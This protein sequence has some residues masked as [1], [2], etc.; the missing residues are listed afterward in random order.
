MR[1]SGTALSWALGPAITES[2]FFETSYQRRSLSLPS[3]ERDRFATL[4]DREAL[5]RAE[6]VIAADAAT[7]DARGHQVQRE[8]EPRELAAWLA[9]GWTVCADVSSHP[10]VQAFLDGFTTSF[11]VAGARPFAKAYA[12]PRGKGFALHADAHEV[13][14]LQLAGE[15]RW[16][17][18]RVP[19]LASPW[20]ALE[21]S[22]GE[23][24]YVEPRAGER[25]RD[26]NGEPLEPPSAGS[27]EEVILRS[28]DVLYLPAGA[29]HETEAVSESLA[30]SVSPPL[31]RGRDVAL[32]LIAELLEGERWRRSSSGREAPAELAASLDG[33]AELL[34]SVD[35]RAL[36][37]AHC[38]RVAAERVRALPSS[39]VSE[40]TEREAVIVRDDVLVRASEAPLMT[41]IAPGDE[42]ADAVFFYHREEELSFPLEARA[43]VEALSRRD[44]FVAQEARQ[45]DRALDWETIASLLGE[46]VRAGVLRRA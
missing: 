15:K 29:W 26:D 36:V 27:L 21:V 22:E 38:A 6:G 35:R 3:P 32:A 34:A 2:E 4:F 10:R 23:V 7:R 33:I 20:A 17:Y 9:K 19:A 16:R 41:L 45:W 42:G 39:A 28:G 24:V 8:I 40:A 12:S 30:L 11:V 18:S 14:V 31:V 25:V 5:V 1:D 37:R 44:R 46:L 13:F 43:F